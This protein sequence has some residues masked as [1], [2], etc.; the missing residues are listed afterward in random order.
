TGMAY[1]YVQHLSPAHKSF[2][3]DILSKTTKM[4]VQEIENM[5]HMAPNNVYV[6]PNDKDIKVTDGHIQL[7]PR[8]KGG[9]A[10]S[11]DV[12][13]SSLAATHKENVIGVVLSGNAHDGTIG[14][15]AIKE[16][17]GVTFAQDG[18]AQ[19]SSMPNSAIQAGVVDYILSPKKIARSL[20]KLAKI[21]LNHRSNT[22][23]KAEQLTLENKDKIKSDDPDLRIVMDSLLK[24]MHVDFKLYKIATI[25]R[26]IRNRMLQNNIRTIKKYAEFIVK[27]KKEIA[28][29]YKDLLIHVTSFFRDVET[30]Q[31]LKSTFFP[32]FFKN[33]PNTD[34]LRLWIPACSTGEEVYSMAMILTELQENSTKKYSFQIFATDLSD[35]AIRIARAGE[36]AETDIKKISKKRL[37]QFFTKTGDTYRIVKELREKCIFAPHNILSDPPFSRID[38]ISC[39]NLLIY[40]DS[41]AQKKTLKSIYF[42]LNEGA[43]LM[44]G[45]SETP[46]T[47][48]TLFNPVNTRF[49]IYSRKKNIGIRILP[50]L[51]YR[52]RQ[53]SIAEKTAK[54]IKKTAAFN[55]IALD[56]AVDSELLSRYMPT[57]VV[58]NKS[59]EI[60]KF[61]GLTAVYL[62]HPSGN[63]SLNIL[64]MI[65]SEF[66]FELRN[67]IQESFKTN[68]PVLKSEIEMNMRSMDTL[69][70]VLSIEVCPMKIEWGEPLFM[71]VFTIQ[72]EVEKFIET[73][74]DRNSNLAQKDRKIKRQMDELNK[75]SSEMALVIESQ[76]K[77]YEELQAANEEIISASEEFQTLN[78][79]LETSK[80]EIEA[81][82]EELL[83]T[84]QELQMRNEQL[85]ESHNFAEAVS[86]TMHEPMLILDR[87]LRI[88]SA[89]SAF[90][91]KFHTHRAITESRLLYELGDHQW[92]IPSLRPLLENII[93]KNTHFYDYEIS[94][95]FPDIG[96]KIMLLNARKIIQKTQNEQLILLTFID[97][98]GHAKKRI[99]ER[100]EL[101]D[102]ISER[103][104][105]LEKSHRSLETKN[106]FLEKMN[107]ELETFTFLSSHDLQ[108]PLRKIR[109]LSTCLLDE[110]NRRLSNSGQGYLKR[111]QD[112]VVRMQSL[113][114]DLLIYASARKSDYEFQKADLNKIAEEVIANFQDL[115][116]E[117]KGKIKSEGFCNAHIIGL[118]FRQV[119]DNLIGNSLKFADPNR[120][121]R[122]VIK[123][124]IS[125]GIKLKR[126]E[127][128]PKLNYCHISVADNGIGF[129]P[130][131][132]DQIFEVFQR[133]HGQKQ[134]KGTG[135]G[136]AICKRI[137]ENHNGLITATGVLNK[138]TQID[139]YIPAS[140]AEKADQN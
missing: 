22:N 110:E 86:E 26:R 58:I 75:T 7:I 33:N 3:T 115:L 82:N 128:L 5:E 118:Q 88:K 117:K 39:R 54:P 44:L 122:I 47:S 30:F 16:S 104:N 35:Q 93:Q 32:K 36:Y 38:F 121:P 46:G 9:T 132:K 56:Q 100:Q 97:I 53:A 80:E 52:F 70:G 17:G 101:E 133:L 25:E 78:E 28:L 14:L 79:E 114:Q 61:R 106:I 127:L 27:N 55:S 19:A 138:G 67:A 40:F 73:T 126:K 111:I 92:D 45:K 109:M 105:D 62:S 64:K 136:L 41:I 131:Y 65:R 69:S 71:V 66:A 76:D 130:K 42:A 8:S 10:I 11:I 123:S 98:T 13:F 95:E 124:R 60:L 139:I 112:I 31:Y 90:Y 140:D 15:K 135:I 50:E 84:N 63:A 120:P 119:L 59:M 116:N 20:V 48:S 37:E 43:Y 57:C 137:V 89:N 4:K 96:K 125:L 77:A 85:A 81:T 49:R 29:L 129:D 94:H 113:I 91:K 2:L 51:T 107:K 99:L 34:I 83:T 108:E 102:I 18:S 103:T 68:K 134:Y 72:K 23:D 1:I 87:H 12:L 74:K 24:E 21:D 6:I